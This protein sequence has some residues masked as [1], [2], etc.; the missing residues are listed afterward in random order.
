M[1]VQPFDLNKVPSPWKPILIREVE[2]L[3]KRQ[4]VTVTD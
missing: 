2:K 4:D 3:K 1:D